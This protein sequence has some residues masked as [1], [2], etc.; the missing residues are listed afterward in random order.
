MVENVDFIGAPREGR[1]RTPL[2][3][4]DFEAYRISMKSIRMFNFSWFVRIRKIKDL[5]RKLN[6]FRDCLIWT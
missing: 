5:E 1:T 4:P 2:P 6:A 3:E